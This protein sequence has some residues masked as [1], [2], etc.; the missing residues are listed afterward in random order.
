MKDKIIWGFNQTIFFFLNQC[1]QD[2]IKPLD[3][4]VVKRNTVSFE[5]L[6][7]SLVILSSCH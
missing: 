7:R 5:V 2:S 1:A 4:N 3:S 6:T